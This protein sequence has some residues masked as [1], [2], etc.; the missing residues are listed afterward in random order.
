MGPMAQLRRMTHG[1]RPADRMKAVATTKSEAQSKP[2]LSQPNAVWRRIG[3]RIEQR[4]AVV[5]RGVVA[6]LG[7]PLQPEETAACVRECELLTQWLFSLDL[8]VAG[9][10][11]RE[12]AEAFADPQLSNR[13]ASALAS[14]V[15]ELRRVLRVA[16]DD[17][18]DA[19]REALHVHVVSPIDAHIDALMWHLQQRGALT[20]HSPTFMSA[21]EKANALVVYSPTN[22]RDT[23][24]LLTAVGR[25]SA[26]TRRVIVHDIDVRREHLAEIAD[27]AD[28]VVPHTTPAKQLSDEVFAIAQP[29][30]EW[31][32]RVVLLGA[33]DLYPQL[34]PFRFDVLIANNT[35]EA[36][37]TLVGTARTLVIG[38]D[39]ANPDSIVALAR[40]TPETRDAL[41]VVAGLEEGVAQR[42]RHLGADL[43]VDA[44]TSPDVWALHLRG[45]IGRRRRS[46]DLDAA[47]AK[48]VPSW[49]RAVVLL[50]RALA[51]LGRSSSIASLALIDKPELSGPDMEALYE[52]FGSEFRTDD[53]LGE[54]DDG[55]LIVLLKGAPRAAAS[56]R[57]A[58]ALEHLDID[59]TC[60]RAGVVEFP[61][62]GLGLGQLMESAGSLMAQ[63]E[64]EHGPAV[65][66]RDWSTGGD[67]KVDVL[68]VE[69]DP[70]LATVLQQLLERMDLTSRHVSTGSD[71]LKALT[72]VDAAVRPRLLLLE[73]DAMGADGLMVLRSLARQQVLSKT[74]V[75]V[76][77]ARIRDG[78]LREAFELG[79]ADV[80]QKPFSA[81]VLQ[82]RLAQVLG[83]AVEP[84]E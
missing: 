62:E 76:T 5:E 58:L 41:L 8:V 28:L 7:R 11:T 46:G 34:V 66:S 30:P 71:A 79:A 15:E 21:P 47:S 31:L 29:D 65:A 39:I 61:A 73:L 24:G 19:P 1:L 36:M 27:E 63:A 22:L 80:V 49:P 37:R 32:N 4:M 82:N 40:S 9:R 69:S 20:T 42:T 75:V 51:T 59:P 83:G 16:G 3:D 23:A 81:V 74:K 38:P 25:R 72:G 2:W 26:S 53:L 12:L 50:D 55:R 43:I 57:I 56:K 68:L 10:L 48:T 14:R 70:T 17:W 52:G 67:G 64:D 13:S 35:E 77:A 6:L 33:N 44:G 45:L 54:S 60:G 78:E 18:R 84:L